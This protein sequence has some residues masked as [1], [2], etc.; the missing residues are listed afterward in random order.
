MQLW[1]K[2]YISLY[3][4][5]RTNEYLPFYQYLMDLKCGLMSKHYL[6]VRILLH[7]VP[8]ILFMVHMYFL[9]YHFV[10]H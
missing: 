2:W 10:L 9:L 7:T 6:Y 8:K 3:A 4:L 5:E 1:F